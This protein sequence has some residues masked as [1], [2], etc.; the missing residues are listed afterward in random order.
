MI[1][2]YHL[3]AND[4]DLQLGDVSSKFFS[5]SNLRIAGSLS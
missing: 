3:D 1:G 2:E 5:V 4:C